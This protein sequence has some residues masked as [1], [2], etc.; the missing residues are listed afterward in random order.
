M[1]EVARRSKKL[2]LTVADSKQI[3]E[4]RRVLGKLEEKID[5]AQK[6]Q[7][8][9]GSIEGYRVIMDEVYELSNQYYEALA[10]TGFAYAA[11]PPILQKNEVNEQRVILQ[12]LYDIEVAFKIILGAKQRIKEIHPFDYCT[13]ALNVDMKVLKEG[14][15]SEYEFV[16]H[17]IE[18]SYRI[19]DQGLSTV[20]DNIKCIIKVDSNVSP[21]LHPL[22]RMHR[23]K[24]QK[25]CSGRSTTT[26]CCGTA[27]QLRTCWEYWRKE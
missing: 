26:R 7:Q 15:D 23:R 5:E 11:I 16:K 20:D 27:H 4:A 8:K 14:S 3:E 17:H 21:R 12:D 13:S 9:R 19:L 10:P 18:P 25:K 24:R 1:K 6:E 2:L 22:L